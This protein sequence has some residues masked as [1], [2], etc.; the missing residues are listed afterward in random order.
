MNVQH[1]LQPMAAVARLDERRDRAILDGLR[2]IVFQVDLEGRWV[3]LN[4]AWQEL[5]GQFA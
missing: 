3:Y 2:N 1:Q 5:T 4:A